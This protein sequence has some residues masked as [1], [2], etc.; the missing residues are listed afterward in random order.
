MCRDFCHCRWYVLISSEI[1]TLTRKWT[2]CLIRRRDGCLST[3]SWNLTS[4]RSSQ[5]GRKRSADPEKK[6]LNLDITEL[7]RLVLKLQG[8]D[9][10]PHDGSEQIIQNRQ[11]PIF[12]RQNGVEQGRQLDRPQSAAGQERILRGGRV[13]GRILGWVRK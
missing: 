7:C 10:T 13:P 2:I 3:L 4:S 11:G 12:S 1:Q 9:K 5:V 6:Y 8:P